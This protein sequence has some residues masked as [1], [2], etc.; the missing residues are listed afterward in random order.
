MCF[1]ERKEFGVNTPNKM[2]IL[3]I[4]LGGAHD[5]RKLIKGVYMIR[6]RGYV[7]CPEINK[8]GGGGFN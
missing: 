6:P 2:G 7:Q 1:G 3:K 8:Q 4:E 5:V